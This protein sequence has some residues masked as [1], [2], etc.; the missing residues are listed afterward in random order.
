MHTG[1]CAHSQGLRKQHSSITDPFTTADLTCL[2]F[3]FFS[4]S[5]SIYVGNTAWVCAKVRWLKNLKSAGAH[6]VAESK[7]RALAA[8]LVIFTISMHLDSFLD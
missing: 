7:I 6:D 5:F 2:L 1:V 3:S 8:V 4:I